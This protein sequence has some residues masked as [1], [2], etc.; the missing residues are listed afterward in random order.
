MLS[1]AIIYRRSPD[2]RP[3]SVATIQNRSILAHAAAEAIQE[4][5]AKADELAEK[6]HVLGQI[7]REEAD[8]LKR[9]LSA[10]VGIPDAGIGR[11]NAV[12]V[13]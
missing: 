8:K 6:D 3:L 2:G 13:Q 7:Q 4:A 5:F 1:L 12:T 10:L 9:V 11:L